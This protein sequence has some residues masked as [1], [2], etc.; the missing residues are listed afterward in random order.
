M[1]SKFEIA[2]F[3]LAYLIILISPIVT[4]DIVWSND[5]PLDMPS[6]GRGGDE[7][8]EDAPEVID[9]WGGQYE[10]DAFF[11]CLD[12]SCSMG[13]NGEIQQL[14]QEFS[15]TL[16][17]LSSQAEFGVVAFSEGHISWNPAPQ[18][19][20]PA[21][22][23]SATAWVQSLQA[24]GWTCLGP[25]AVETINIANQS[26]KQM[27]QILVLSDGEPYCNGSNTSNQVLND[28]S[29]ANWQQI[30][31]NTIYIASDSGGIMF[32]QQLANQNNGTFSNP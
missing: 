11:W 29:A 16:N 23:G 18:K 13:W 2:F 5:R 12:K 8:E 14:K 22:K 3:F 20:N 15:Q 30:P 10:G 31:V 28:V 26:N 24:A 9:F 27:K 7:D 32:M 17:S 19:A 1:L 4:Y 21:N 6:G 25:A